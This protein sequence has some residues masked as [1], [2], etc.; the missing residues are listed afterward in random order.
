MVTDMTS[1][2]IPEIAR[3]SWRGRIHTWAFFASLPAC[4]ALVVVARH[5]SAR[6]AAAI[7]GATLLGVFGTSAA[8]HRLAVSPKARRVMRRLD[9]AM[10]YLLI[11]GTYTPV[12]L[13][14]LPRSWGIPVLAVVGTGAVVG[15]TLKLTVFDRMKWL[16]YALYPILGWAAAIALPVLATHV[17][18]LT[19]GLI[20]AG[21]L[22]YSAG[23]P[24]LLAHRPDPWP[25][26][27]GYHEIWHAFTVAAG[28]CH[29]AAVGMIVRA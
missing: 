9:H 26:V 1:L 13:V 21:G 29:F 24:I 14:A 17:S 4:I 2:G 28:A 11:A 23:L 10:I 25:S 16:A 6:T 22:L 15:F 12:C 27:F 20:V 5:A 18:G 8:Y 3:P 19:F 7:Y